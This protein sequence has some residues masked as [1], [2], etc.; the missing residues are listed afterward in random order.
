[1]LICSVES[2]SW[3]PAPWTIAHQPLLSMGFYGE[4]YWNGLPFLPPVDLS[5]PGI[6]PASLISPALPGMFFTTSITWE[7]MCM[8]I[9]VCM[10]I[11]TKG[12]GLEGCALIFSSE[13]TEIV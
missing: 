2:D 13:N 12:G 9:Y 5:N 7:A 8:Y 11:Y 4:E 10:Y 6:K 3:R 1:M